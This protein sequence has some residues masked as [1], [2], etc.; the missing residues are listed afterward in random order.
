[1]VRLSGRPVLDP[2]KT[3]QKVK[4]LSRKKSLQKPPSKKQNELHESQKLINTQEEARVFNQNDEINS[5]VKY[6]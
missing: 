2:K 6:F 3:D 5:D 4:G 1:M